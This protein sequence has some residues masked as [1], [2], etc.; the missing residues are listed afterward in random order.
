MVRLRRGP[1]REVERLR[2]RGIGRPLGEGTGGGSGTGSFGGESSRLRMTRPNSSSSSA[3]GGRL[4]WC[5]G[6]GDVD[7]PTRPKYESICTDSRLLEAVVSHGDQWLPQS[8]RCD[9]NP[10]SRPES[11]AERSPAPR[12]FRPHREYGEFRCVPHA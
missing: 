11:F 12:S 9:S 8:N 2:D 7:L 5:P 4:L 10:R 1:S 3:G 6:E